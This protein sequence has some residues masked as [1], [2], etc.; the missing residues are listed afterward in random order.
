MSLSLKIKG[1]KADI[2]SMIKEGNYKVEYSFYGCFGGG[3]ET[4]E[5][6]NNEDNKDTFEYFTT[7]YEYRLV[8]DSKY[9]E[10]K[11]SRVGSKRLAP[12]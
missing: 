1:G 3:T 9:V 7:T 11:E 4:L 12:C 10:F 2:Q 5:V 6:E 8:N